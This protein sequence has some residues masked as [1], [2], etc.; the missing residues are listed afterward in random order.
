MAKRNTSI[1]LASDSKLFLEGTEK[2]LE[3]SEGIKIVGTAT[4]ISSVEKLIN[5]KTPD[6]LLL[7]DRSDNLQIGQI[8]TLTNVKNSTVELI[9]FSENDVNNTINLKSVN[10]LY[11]TEPSDLIDVLIN[12]KASYIRKSRSITTNPCNITEAEHKVIDLIASG[13]T[14]KEIASTLHISPK[15]VKAHI[16]SIFVKLDIQNRYQLMVYGKRNKRVAI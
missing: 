1:L 10:L 9:L 8:L 12:G 16:T 2:L 11:I 5:E 4:N 7:D 6:Y 14:N 13:H 3:N 15:T